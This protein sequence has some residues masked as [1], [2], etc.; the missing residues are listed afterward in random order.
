MKPIAK[1]GGLSAAQTRI[2]WAI[3][4]A[5]AFGPLSCTVGSI[6][7]TDFVRRADFGYLLWWLLMCFVTGWPIA[8]LLVALGALAF[9][10]K[11]QQ[12]STLAMGGAIGS[13]WS[14]ALRSRRRYMRP[15]ILR[16]AS[17]E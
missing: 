12:R 4:I 2:G 11:V 7:W 17:H 9:G 10:R 1:R 15:R 5:S 16:V 13:E 6:D 8:L 14:S 3:I